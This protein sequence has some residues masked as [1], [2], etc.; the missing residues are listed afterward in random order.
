MKREMFRNSVRDKR[1]NKLSRL[2]SMSLSTTTKAAGGSNDEGGGKGP[3]R[4]FLRMSSRG[5]AR[6][7]PLT[8][9]STTE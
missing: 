1:A 3:G 2:L 8:P 6:V 5:V 4:S 9:E 7:A